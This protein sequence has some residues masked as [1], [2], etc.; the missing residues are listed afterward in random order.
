MAW[1]P[2]FLY[3]YKVCASDMHR[4]RKPVWLWIGST[5]NTYQNTRWQAALPALQNRDLLNFFLGLLP[6]PKPRNK[7]GVSM[8]KSDSTEIW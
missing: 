3:L 6:V 5:V 8:V 4:K 1:A 7:S 2:V